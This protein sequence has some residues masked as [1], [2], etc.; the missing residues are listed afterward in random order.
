MML[1]QVSICQLD[2]ASCCPVCSSASRSRPTEEILHCDRNHLKLSQPFQ[3]HCTIVTPVC[4]V[5]FPYSLE[6]NSSWTVRYTNIGP[7]WSAQ[8]PGASA[9][10]Q[11][12]VL[13][14]VSI[15]SYHTMLARLE[16]LAHDPPLHRRCCHK[17]RVE[18]H[19][20]QNVTQSK[21]LSW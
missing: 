17:S 7:H 11:M 3:I 20:H 12:C 19:H 15:P 13:R 5:L 10:K 2:T 14:T 18:H 8:H 9:P 16:L 1:F 6:A 4:L 21:I